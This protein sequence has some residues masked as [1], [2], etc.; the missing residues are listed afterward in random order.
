MLAGVSADYYARLEQGRERNPSAPVVDA[1]GRALHLSPE[2]R[3]HLFRLAAL[4]PRSGGGAPARAR[5][6]RVARRAGGLPVGG[7]LRPGPGAGRAGRERDR[8]GAAVPVRS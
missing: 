5:R 3:E 8:R 7:G 2:A 6:S 1:I 4:N